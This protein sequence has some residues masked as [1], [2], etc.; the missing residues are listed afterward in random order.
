MKQEAFPSEA[1]IDQVELNALYRLTDRLYR[2]RSLDEVYEAA[3]DAI[4]TTLRCPRASILLFDSSG[5]MQFVAWRG[6][7]DHYRSALRGHSP[8]KPGEPDPHPIFVS[9]IDGADEADWVKAAIKAEGIVALGFIP[10]VSQGV[11][12]G[13]FM[14]YYAEPHAFEDHEVDLAVTIARQVGFSIERFTADLARQ[15]AEQ[16][17]RESEQRFRLM[18]EHAPVMIWMSQPDGSCLHLNQMLRAFW[19]VEEE[20]VAEFNWRSTMHPDDADEIVA[21]MTKALGEHRQVSLKGRFRDAAGEWRVLQTDARPRF[22]PSGEFLGMIGVNVDITERE[23]SDAERRRAEEHAQR[24]A[25]IVASSD[26]AI[27]SKDLN[28]VI[29]SWNQAA[30]RLFG[31]APEEVIGKSITILIPEERLDEEPVIL[32]RIRGGEVIDHY[33]TVRRRKDGSL[34]DI[35]LTVSPIKN[36]E[37][38]I[39]GVSKIA[40]DITEKRR[41]EERQQ[42]LIREMAHRVKNLFAVS[43]G[44]VSLSARYAGNS[45]DLATAIRERLGALSRAHALTLPKTAGDALEAT[46]PTTLHTLIRTI[47]LP[48]EEDIDGKGA[49][50]AIHGP[51]VPIAAGVVTNLALL[52][53]EFATNA[54]KYGALSTPHGTVDVALSIDDD[55]VSLVW[56]ER[57]GPAV[58]QERNQGFGSYLGEAT[59]KR[60][61]GGEISR[62]WNQGGVTIRLSVARDRLEE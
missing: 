51:D 45:D 48:Y 52:L 15:S 54:V 60:Q 12:I 32:G 39:V 35:S 3:L 38:R 43:S 46:R 8:W 14:T 11:V 18:S 24:L 28:G 21:G 53:H 30:E 47:M 23:R 61:L 2:A 41:A 25:A 57:G 22:S 17:L 37:G 20:E 55:Q 6:L 44:V 7:S 36:A 5:V 56:T 13:K 49:R 40:R 4:A 50:V 34:L 10:L 42:L 62:D 59:V 29:T 19:N 26:D 9:D 1:A 27:I 16:E 31:Y 58:G 33:E